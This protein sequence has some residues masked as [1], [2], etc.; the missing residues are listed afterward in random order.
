MGTDCPKQ[1]LPIG[2]VPILRGRYNLF[3]P[4]RK[5]TASWLCAVTIC[6][7]KPE[8]CFF[9]FTQKNRFSLHP[10]GKRG[11]PLQK[12]GFLRSP[13][14]ARSLTLWSF[15]MRRARSY[16][17]ASFHVVLQVRKCTAPARQP[18]LR[19]T[20]LPQRM[21]TAASALSLTAVRFTRSRRRRPFP[22][23]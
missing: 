21:W 1:F 6:S 5:S 15:T 3:A 23:R 16:R 17:T 11:R 18:F 12:T 7:I 22:F 14:S 10:A 19:R 20:R 13:R 2:G 4:I 8:A 9:P